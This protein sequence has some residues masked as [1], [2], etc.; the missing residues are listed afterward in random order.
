MAPPQRITPTSLADHYEQLLRVTFQPGMSWRVIDAKW[1]G[2]REAFD[3][4]EP[5]V[6]SAY[7]PDRVDELSVDTRIVRN[8]KKIE[9]AVHNA[10]VMVEHEDDGG[11]EPWLRSF[12]DY[13]S[14]SK[15]LRKAFT[16][17]GA[18]GVYHYL[19][20]VSEPVPPYEDVFGAPAV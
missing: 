8:R 12:G 6:V 16:F 19:Y 4:F 13:E 3:G 15:G 2:F 10:R 9:A 5:R 14:T 7:D 11:Y 1:P 20:V 18:M 17:L